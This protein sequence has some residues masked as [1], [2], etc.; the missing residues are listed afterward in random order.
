MTRCRTKISRC[1]RRCCSVLAIL[2]LIFIALA[3][4]KVYLTQGL[5]SITFYTIIVWLTAF[6]ASHAISPQPA[7]VELFIYLLV[8]IVVNIGSVYSLPRPTD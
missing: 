4:H 8:A 6:D 2:A 1:S 5:Q 7:D 3:V